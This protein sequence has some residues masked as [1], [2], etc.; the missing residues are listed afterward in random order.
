MIGDSLLI[1]VIRIDHVSLR[2]H[3]V[4][5]FI[6][7]IRSSFGWGKDGDWDQKTLTSSIYGT[8]ASRPGTYCPKAN[9]FFEVPAERIPS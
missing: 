2:S 3:L 6:V 9:P 8:K 7:P 5:Y 1:Y 4:P